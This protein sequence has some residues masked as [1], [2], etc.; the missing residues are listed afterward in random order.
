MCASCLYG[1]TVLLEKQVPHFFAT[2]L[3]VQALCP[4]HSFLQELSVLER[5]EGGTGIGEALDIPVHSRVGLTKCNH[6]VFTVSH[7]T[8]SEDSYHMAKRS[9]LSI[10]MLTRCLPV[11]RSFLFVP[12]QP[13]DRLHYPN[14]QRFALQQAFR[15]IFAASNRRWHMGVPPGRMST[16]FPCDESDREQEVCDI[17]VFQCV[18][19][20]LLSQAS[21]TLRFYHA[22]ALREC[23][24]RDYLSSNET[25]LDVGVDDSRGGA[26]R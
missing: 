20:A 12:L 23:V 13:G 1:G 18:I 2:R 10:D 8:F 6:P 14:D 22:T 7:H 26:G 11:S 21:R 15:A 16:R 5:S 3:D 17:T 24:E 4:I 19:P 9:F 25:A